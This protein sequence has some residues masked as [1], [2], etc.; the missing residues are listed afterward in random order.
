M[1]TI[2]AERLNNALIL[3]VDDIELNQKMLTHSLLGHGYGKVVIAGDG[4]QALQM[5]HELKPD[6]VILDLMMPVMDG[7]AY[8]QAIR[9]DKAFDN[10]PILV[11]TALEDMDKKLRAF[12]LGASDYICK[13]VDPGE[14]IARTE[15]H[16]SQKFLMEDLRAYR[17]RMSAELDA[18]KL[19]QGRLMPGGPHI[20]MCE[21]VYD[22]KID[23]YFETSFHLG[24]ECWGI[25][26]L[27]D[28]RRARWM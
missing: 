14:L 22:M 27:S 11:Q 28:K 2:S 20:H 23:A 6:L 9:Q 7:Y 18:A 1:D 8:C 15:V 19:M 3:V 13:P 10:M 25:R 21:R 4:S 24:G 26:P 5:T 17:R 16:L 12:E